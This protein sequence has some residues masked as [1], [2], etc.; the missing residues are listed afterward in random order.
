MEITLKKLELSHFKGV[1]SFTLEVNGNGKNATI[2][3]RNGAGKTTLSDAAHWLLF[4]KDSLGRADFSI[5]TLDK[6]GNELHNLDHSVEGVFDVDGQEITLKKVFREKW[7]R[8]RGAASKEFTGHEVNHFIDDV[9]VKES[10]FKARI[11]ALIDENTFKLLTNP[12]YF[13]SLHWQ[14]RREILLQVCGNVSDADVIA[15]NKDLAALPEILGNRSLEDHKKVIASKKKEINDRLKDIPGRIDENEKSIVDVSGYNVDEINA[16]ITKLE[17]K[18]QTMKAGGN[19]AVL[20]KQKAELEAKRAEIQTKL[21]GLVREAEKAIDGEIE[22]MEK[23]NRVACKSLADI[24]I[25]LGSLNN[26]IDRNEKEMDRLRKEFT[27]VAAQEYTGSSVCPT[28]GQS[29]PEDQV[30]AAVSKHNE[31]KARRIRDINDQGKR[32][33]VATEDSRKIR[34]R[35]IEKK[36]GLEE[37]IRITDTRIAEERERG[38]KTLAN[39]GKIEKKALADLAAE[40]KEA[41]EGLNAAPV[42]TTL[43]DAELTTEKGK[44]AEIEGSKKAAKRIEALKREEKKLAAEYE[45][46]ERQTFLMEGF[47]R[48]KV[49]L[50]E[51]KI[52]SRFSLVRWKLFTEQINGGLTE[53]CEATIDGVPFS[54]ANTGSQILAGLDIISTLQRHY[55]IKAVCWLDHAEALSSAPPE[56]NCQMIQLHVSQDKALTV[57]YN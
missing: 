4:G 6:S 45:D 15:S 31:Q 37:D 23:A 42:D 7:V 20:R 19:D 46:L 16:K 9:P 55:N 27:E 21:D 57:S 36:T 13:N 40:I 17:S 29:L 12:S 8:K 22:T 48:A 47:I 41:D 35:L 1:R 56:M 11:A 49:N 39:V 25:E 44:L 14:K 32:L 43:L 18:I 10:E 34:E 26:V 52:N 30:Q 38:F 51:D 28:C 50:L 5:K 2:R 33:K 54:S 24:S 53:C 3:G